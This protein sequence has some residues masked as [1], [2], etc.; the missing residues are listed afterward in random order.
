MINL[1]LLVSATLSLTTLITG[2]FLNHRLLVIVSKTLTSVIMVIYVSL[3]SIESSFEAAYLIVIA[4]TL[5][6]FG[7]V[8]LLGKSTRFFAAG[9]V[10]FALGHLS[11]ILAFAHYSINY[12]EL[13]VGFVVLLLPLYF[14]IKWL[15]KDI[16]QKLR[17][18]VVGYVLILTAMTATAMAVRIDGQL[19]LMAL[20]ATL[21][22]ISDFFVATHRFK[23]KKFI[24]KAIGLPLYYSGQFILATTLVIQT[25]TSPWLPV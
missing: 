16:P 15:W 9:M 19:T 20:G 22:L 18:P 3:L 24:D 4:I 23:G 5:G 12:I 13:L 25:T 8:F 11:Y 7:D 17:W 6:A 1:V 21:F 10:A 2:Q 14:V